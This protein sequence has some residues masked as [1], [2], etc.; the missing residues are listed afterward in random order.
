MTTI[1]PTSFAATRIQDLATVVL[2]IVSARPSV[3]AENVPPRTPGEMI[4]FYN[5]SIDRVE[6]FV[7]SAGGTFWREIG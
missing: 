7:A 1:N 5:P 4:G 3:T 6:V 2:P